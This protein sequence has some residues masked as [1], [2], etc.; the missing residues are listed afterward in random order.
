MKNIK[1]IV[2][3]LLSLPLFMA[4]CMNDDFDTPASTSY[5]TYTGE[6]VNMTINDLKS[7]YYTAISKDSMALIDKGTIIEGTVTSSDEHGNFYQQIV[8]QDATGAIQINAS[9]KGQHIYYP[10]GQKVVVKC[11][12]LYIGGYGKA[13]LLGVDYYNTNKGKHQVGRMSQSKKEEVLI[14]DGAASESNLPAPKEITKYTDLTNNDINLLVTLKD[15][16]FEDAEYKTFAPE[17]EADG[18]GGVDRNIHF[19]NNS[20]L[21]VRTSTYANFANTVLPGKTGDLTGIIGKYNS[22]WQFI[23]RD[24]TTDIGSTF[25]QYQSVRVPLFSETLASSLG[26]MVP[27][28]VTNESVTDVADWSFSSSYNCALVS[29]YVNKKNKAV[30]SYLITPT[31]DL[32]STEKAFVSFESAIAYPNEATTAYMHQ[33]LVSADYNGDPSTAT[34]TVIPFNA[35]SNKYTF[36]KTGKVAVPSSFV[37]KKV[38]FAL[39]YKSTS[40][41][42][43]TWEVKNFMVDEGE[44]STYEMPDLVL[45]K[46]SL[47]STNAGFTAFSVNG[48]QT[49]DLDNSYGFKM[50]GYYKKCYENEDWAVSPEID[51]SGS[52]APAMSFDHAINKGAKGIDLTAYHTLWITDN[53]TGDVTTTKWTQVTIP[54][55]PAGTNWTFVGSGNIAIPSSFAGK[56]IRIAFKYESTAS[57]AS[58]WEVKNLEVK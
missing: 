7:K 47:Q 9:G 27:K 38:T 43:S 44:G 26:T 49:W 18:G 5:S 46:S 52:E 30:I 53:F 10:I 11:D 15:V 33:L 13:A 50:S 4:S 21:V 35:K 20:Y 19:S 56:T 58:T 25:E 3:S 45:F 2:L 29:G 14:P 41:K 37:G 24:Y 54:T 6:P 42:A 8:I 40:K 36:Y 22:T 34:W 51:L 16:S 1:Y 23:I 39:R 57:S 28:H 31:V 55:Y 48:T 32:T 12:S 17:A